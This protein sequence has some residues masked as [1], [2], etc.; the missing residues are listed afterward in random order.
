VQPELLQTRYDDLIRWLGMLLI[1][2][3]AF[4]RPMLAT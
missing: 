4:T 1:S 3:Q 2:G